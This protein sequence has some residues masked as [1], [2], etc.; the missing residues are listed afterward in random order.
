MEVSGQHNA[1][2]AVPR[3]KNAGT[4]W[5]GGSLGPREG[6]DVLEKS[7]LSLPGFE[8]QTFQPLAWSVYVLSHPRSR[9]KKKGENERKRA[10]MCLSWVARCSMPLGGA[11]GKG[12]EE[13][14]R[15][16]DRPATCSL[17]TGLTAAVAVGV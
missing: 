9:K 12:C 15:P 8:T 5:V 3:G 2:A 13:E 17:S 1:P 16:A 7:V 4:N 6:L 14:A 11:S 10:K